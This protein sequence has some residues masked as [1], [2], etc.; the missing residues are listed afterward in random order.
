MSVVSDFWERALH[1]LSVP[2]CVLCGEPLDFPSRALCPVCFS[3][4]ENTKDRN[5]PKCARQL[6]QCD[7]STKFLKSHCVKRLIKVCRY[8][9]SDENL[10][11]NSLI[12]SLK[13]DNRNDVAKL[14]SEELAT[15]ISAS[16]KDPASYIF[17]NVPRRQKAIVV[18]G[19]DHSAILA[20]AIAKRFD[21]EYMP[22]LK[23]RASRPQKEM[24]GRDRLK[25]A[26]V[27]PRRDINLS[28]KRI[29]LIDDIVTTGASMAVSA[30]A[31]RG[32]G[33]KEVVGATVAIAY[34]KD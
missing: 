25:N 30:M 15:A 23:S 12:Y 4:Y 16:V 13:K 6:C 20:K 14:L 29:I 8:V 17:T 10:A 2:K 7:C 24:Q 1:L 33:A 9:G 31:L 21:A 26:E 3:K 5:C 28:G 18:Y 11:A 22:L 27:T 19:I 34:K 32:M